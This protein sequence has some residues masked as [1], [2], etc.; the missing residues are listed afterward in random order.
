MDILS[1]ISKWR[2]NIKKYIRKRDYIYKV[3]YL[4]KAKTK[5][6]VFTSYI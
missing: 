3:I 1:V 5:S 2:V 4:Y 6:I